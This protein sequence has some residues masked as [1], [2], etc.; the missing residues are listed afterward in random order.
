MAEKKAE[1]KKTY[2]N[3]M[4]LFHQETKAKIMFGSWI[5]KDTASCLQLESKN[6]IQ[7]SREDLDKNYTSYASLDRAYRERRRY[8]AW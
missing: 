4:K 3:G 7:I 2:K 6:L 8:E 1:R 5:N